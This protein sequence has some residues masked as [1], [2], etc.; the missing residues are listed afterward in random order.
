[1]N[2]DYI[3]VGAGLGGLSAGLNLAF[4][5]KK[6]LI[7][8]KNSLPGG[9]VTTIK[10]GR[11]EFD[12]SLYDLL[13]YGSE[14][15]VGSLQRIFKK[16]GLDIDTISIPYNIRIKSLDEKFDEVFVGKSNF[17]K[18]F[19]TSEYLYKYFK[20]NPMFDY[21]PIVSGYLKS[22]EQLLY[23]MCLNYRN[24]NKIRYNLNTLNDYTEFIDNNSDMLRSN[25]QRRKKTIV[26]C[27]NSYRIE[28]RNKLFHK[29]YLDKWDRVEQIRKNT[30]FLYVVLLGSVDLSKFPFDLKLLDD[31]YN[32]LFEL[33]DKNEEMYYDLVFKDD[34]FL[35]MRKERCTAGITFN[36]YG[37]IENKMKFIKFAYD[38][39]VTVEISKSHI[40]EEIWESNLPGKNRKRIF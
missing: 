15:H 32:R 37:Q 4:N 25:V 35:K 36:K 8:E 20:K 33:L 30:I 21:T 9:I 7:L 26:N 40:P 11:F 34:K 2:Y 12:T 23:S 14:E 24:A 29:H 1:M 22:I 39:N 18:S 19:L 38:H 27:L 5:K 17:A 16:F 6:V 13:D 28:S 31:R 3:I 10:K